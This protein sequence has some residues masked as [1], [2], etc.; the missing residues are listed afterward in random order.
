VYIVYLSIYLSFLL[1]RLFAFF[2]SVGF[3]GLVEREMIQAFIHHKPHCYH[4]PIAD[5]PIHHQC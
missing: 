2:L 4:L 5:P 3:F 1:A